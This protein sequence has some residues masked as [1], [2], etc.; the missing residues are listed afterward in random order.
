MNFHPALTGRTLDELRE[1]SP[2]AAAL[3]ERMSE[4]RYGERVDGAGP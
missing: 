3:A 2:E 1:V 4:R